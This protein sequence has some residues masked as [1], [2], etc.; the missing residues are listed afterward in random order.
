MA[1]FVL[2][3]GGFHGGWAFRRV[4]KLLR[5]SGHEVYTP[6]LTGLGERS[7]LA[8]MPINLDTHIADV[9]NTILWEDLSDVVLL[10]HSYGGMVITGV[11]EQL[12]DRISALVYLDGLVPEDGNTLFTLRPEYMQ[13]FVAKVAEGGGLMVAPT[14]ASAFDTAQ[15][16]DWAWIDGKV[17]AHPFACFVQAISLQGRAAAVRRRVY[18]YALGGI[19]EG[20]YDRFRNDAGARVISVD[21]G[22]H[23]IMVER[24]E[25]VAEILVEAAL[26]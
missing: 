20:M 2:V 1:T 14:P 21:S 23:S 5:A 12:P 10:G 4:A 15:P 25:R 17:T 6:T 26:P 7:H 11:A 24:P 18:V 22:G 16:G 19:C 13:F 8:C 9:A 3:H